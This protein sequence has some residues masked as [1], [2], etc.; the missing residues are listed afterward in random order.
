MKELQTLLGVD[1]IAAY[2]SI[3]SFFFGYFFLPKQRASYLFP[4]SVNLTSHSSQIMTR[5]QFHHYYPIQMFV[6]F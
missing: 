4:V 5:W 2:L 1:I 6:V 3:F